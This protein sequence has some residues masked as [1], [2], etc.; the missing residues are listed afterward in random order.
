VPKIRVEEAQNV[1][2][3]SNGLLAIGTSLMVFS[4]YRFA[5]QAH[6][7]NQPIALLTL[8]KT[9]A[10]DLANIKLNCSIKDVLL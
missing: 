1:L 5:R 3:N 9:R 7:Y 6:Q 10:D 8:G 4:G 2:K